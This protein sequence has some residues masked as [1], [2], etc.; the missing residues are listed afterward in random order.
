M[1]HFFKSVAFVAITG[2]ALVGCQKE[3]LNIADNPANG[4]NSQKANTVAVVSERASVTSN[5]TVDGV[6]GNYKGEINQVK[7]NGENKASV[8]DRTVK[9][10]KNSN[11]KF[12]LTVDGFS[13]GKM[14]ANLYINVEGITLNSDGTFS[15]RFNK[16]VSLLLTN[17]PAII[18]GKFFKSG[19][20][21]KIEFT[22]QSYGRY[23]IFKKFTASVHF[24]SY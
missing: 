16:G 8:S 3:E 5:F 23:L 17:Y 12:N 9:I 19:N 24:D 2:M 13:V 14:P 22:L 10:T 1:Y 18:N 21:T 4:G 6:V 7:M 15:G 11:N 20:D